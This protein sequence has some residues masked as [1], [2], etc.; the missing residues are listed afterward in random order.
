M[1]RTYSRTERVGQLIQTAIAKLMQDL[2]RDQRGSLV[3]VTDVEVS[4]DYS[5]ARVF[6][7]V[8]PDDKAVLEKVLHTLKLQSK[9]LR[10]ELAQTIELRAMPQ[11]HFLFDESVRTGSHM[12]SLLNQCDSGEDPEK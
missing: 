4:P 7:S 11:L 6:V 10:Y 8:L 1:P 12:S 9:H 2:F 3:T 5:V